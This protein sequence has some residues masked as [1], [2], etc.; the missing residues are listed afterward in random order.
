ME[1]ESIKQLAKSLGMDM[2]GIASIDRFATSDTGKHPH[3]LLPGAKS[4][5]V[6][7]VK[8]LDGVIQANFRAFEDG[9]DQAKGIYGTYG[10]SI[11]PNFLLTYA[12]YA[13][14]Q[15][16]ESNTD[17][18]AT[19]CSTGPMT[20]G[21]QI[22][23]RHAAVAAGLGT[24]GWMGIV[25]TQKFGPRN[26]FGVI[27]T[28]LELDPDPMYSGP[29]LCDPEKCGIC[30]KVCPSQ[31]M[32]AYGDGEPKVVDMGG[33][34]YEYCR[35]DF[36]KCFIV[37]ERLKKEYGGR[38]DWVTSENPTIADV[39][40][41]HRRTPGDESG[42]QRVSSWHCGRCLSYCPAGEWGKKFKSRGLSSGAEN[43]TKYLG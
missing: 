15:N 35:L 40:E 19:P 20:N 23:L 8:L 31:A 32:S 16:I 11:I 24:F 38:E 28:T 14:A 22:S 3:D 39:F 1:K 29:K 43:S 26:R 13:I 37:E 17:E 10:Y 33:E 18:V 2:C 7:G 12:C 25:L 42:L 21:A 34:H 36:A 27:L 4:A 6:I 30:T 9:N 5:I 41:A